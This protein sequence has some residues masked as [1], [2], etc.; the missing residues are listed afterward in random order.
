MTIPKDKENN[1]LNIEVINP[2]NFFL[3]STSVK[4][5]V[6]ENTVKIAVNIL[7]KISRI[8]KYLLSLL[9]KD[10]LYCISSLK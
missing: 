5:F 2:N 4:I 8:V 7:N 10:C 6:P 9:V 3:P 1:K